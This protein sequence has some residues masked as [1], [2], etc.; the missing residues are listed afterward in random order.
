MSCEERRRQHGIP[1]TSLTKASYYKLENSRC[2]IGIEK[3]VS[4]FQ[5]LLIRAHLQMLLERIAAFERRGDGCLVD[6]DFGV[7]FVGHGCSLHS[8]SVIL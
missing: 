2:S 5:V 7:V 1:S 8:M 4:V 6:F 3:N